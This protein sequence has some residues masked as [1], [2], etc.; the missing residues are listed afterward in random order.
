MKL[1]M[2]LVVMLLCLATCINGFA[3][4]VEEKCALCDTPVMVDVEDKEDHDNCLYIMSVECVSYGNGGNLVGISE[5]KLI[6]CDECYD[7]YKMEKHSE[8]SK[9]SQLIFKI[10]DMFDTWV[11]ERRKENAAKI[12]AQ[13]EKKIKELE[14]KIKAL[15]EE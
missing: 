15:K 9:W 5:K 11:K 13:K 14:S 6:V 8:D 1:K 4:H 2:I 3:K 12:I 10:K 7:K